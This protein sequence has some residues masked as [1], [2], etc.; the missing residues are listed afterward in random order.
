MELLLR[1]K[2]NYINEAQNSYAEWK[3]PDSKEYVV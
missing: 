2:M 3:Q 1:N